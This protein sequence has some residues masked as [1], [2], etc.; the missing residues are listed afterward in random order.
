[1]T[2]LFSQREWG[3]IMLA[4]IPLAVSVVVF[5]VERMGWVESSSNAECRCGHGSDL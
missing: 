4:L 1:M 3:A 2:E 5:L